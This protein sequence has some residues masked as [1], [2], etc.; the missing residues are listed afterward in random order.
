MSD[1]SA[2][3]NQNNV[4][5]SCELVFVLQYIDDICRRT[6]G[7]LLGAAL[8]KIQTITFLNIHYFQIM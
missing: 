4:M 2:Q 7:V 6:E 5:A 8:A 1:G 3:F